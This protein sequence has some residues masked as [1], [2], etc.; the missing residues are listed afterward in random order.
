MNH[1]GMRVY[2]TALALFL[3]SIAAKPSHR[4]KNERKGR[5]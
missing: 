2:M 4:G 1:F 5:L 3:T